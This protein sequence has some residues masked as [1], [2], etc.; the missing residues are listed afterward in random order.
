MYS[1]PAPSAFAERLSEALKE[2]LE[3]L[4][5]ELASR[6]HR[7]VVAT[8][9]PITSSLPLARLLVQLLV[10]FRDQAFVTQ[11]LRHLGA[12]LND[13]VAQHYQLLAKQNGL[14]LL[15]FEEHRLLEALAVQQNAAQLGV[16]QALHLVLRKVSRTLHTAFTRSDAEVFETFWHDGHHPGPG[17]HEALAREVEKLL[18]NGRFRLVFGWISTVFCTFFHRDRCV[19]HRPWPDGCGFWGPGA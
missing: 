3:L 8:T 10:P 15:L 11:L 19:L 6:G 14:E 13:L 2:D 17:A 12:H 16:R 9:L 18:R 4:F 1:F 7:R 5:Q